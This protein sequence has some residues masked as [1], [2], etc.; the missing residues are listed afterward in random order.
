MKLNL[1]DNPE[2]TARMKTINRPA[3]AQL[4]EDAFIVLR[5]G[6]FVIALPR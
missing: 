5:T 4:E 6:E 2:F 1:A 3:I